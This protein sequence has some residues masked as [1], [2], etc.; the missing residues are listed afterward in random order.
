MKGLPL[1]IAAA[2]AG[3]GRSVAGIDLSNVGR[4][5]FVGR[6]TLRSFVNMHGQLH[7]AALNEL[8]SKRRRA[9]QGKPGKRWR[10][11]RA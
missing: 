4:E 6:D 3:I 5:Q 2:L 7:P 11:G 9:Q 1:I 10:G 8:A